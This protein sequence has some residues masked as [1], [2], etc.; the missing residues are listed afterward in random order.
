[1]THGPQEKRLE[2]QFKV[3]VE[4]ASEKERRSEEAGETTR[5]VEREDGE[6]EESFREKATRY[7]RSRTCYER[8]QSTPILHRQSRDDNGIPR[9]MS[10]RRFP[11]TAS[12][13]EV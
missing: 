7:S 1:M 4:A 10:E 5:E 12:Q 11:G 6:R 13:N 3:D 8:H 2:A 9:K